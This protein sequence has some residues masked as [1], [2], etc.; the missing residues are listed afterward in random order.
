VSE[1]KLAVSLK[2]LKEG[3][4]VAAYVA[5]EYLAFYL[6]SGT[7]YCTEDVCSHEDKALSEGGFVEGEEVECPHHGSRFNIKTGAAKRFPADLAIRTF[8]IEVRGGDV[9]VAL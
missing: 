9:Y 8:P 5:G 2:D 6:V 1:Y 3:E 7:P 4:V